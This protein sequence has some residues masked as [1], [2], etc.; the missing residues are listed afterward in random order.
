MEVEIHL[1]SFTQTK[2]RTGY[3]I[4]PLFLY[5]A[6]WVVSMTQTIASLFRILMEN[7][8]ASFKDSINIIVFYSQ[9][10]EAGELKHF[11]YHSCN[12]L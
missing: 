2:M 11:K 8:Q 3:F 1:Q 7:V 5:Y 4:S 6:C 9:I 10:P 12:S